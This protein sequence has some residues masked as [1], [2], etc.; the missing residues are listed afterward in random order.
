MM[1]VRFGLVLVLVRGGECCID[2]KSENKDNVQ[3]W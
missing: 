3:W 1:R 2:R